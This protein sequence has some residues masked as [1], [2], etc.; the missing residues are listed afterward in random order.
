MLF[1]Q[2]GGSARDKQHRLHGVFCALLGVRLCRKMAQNRDIYVGRYPVFTYVDG[3]GAGRAPCRLPGERIYPEIWNILTI[4]II[5]S[6]VLIK[7]VFSLRCRQG[8]G[9]CVS[10]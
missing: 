10:V 4:I 5:V 2:R 9:L 6:I 7:H 3:V 8:L 1:R